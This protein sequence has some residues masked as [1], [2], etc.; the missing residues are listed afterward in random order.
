M[1][2][3]MRVI[4]DK[5][6]YYCTYYVWYIKQSTGYNYINCISYALN[7]T[8]ILYIQYVVMFSSYILNSVTP[9]IA[10]E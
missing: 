8:D 4:P 9:A 3:S 10:V 1:S 7:S 6:Y 2:I 5:L